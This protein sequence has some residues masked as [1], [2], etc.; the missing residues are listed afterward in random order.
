M[1]RLHSGSGRFGKK[2]CLHRDRNSR[3]SQCSRTAAS[4]RSP[5]RPVSAAL[6][7]KHR[8]RE[9]W[10]VL[11]RRV[12]WPTHYCNDRINCVTVCVIRMNMSVRGIKCFLIDTSNGR[13]ALLR[14]LYLCIMWVWVDF[15]TK[16]CVLHCIPNFLCEIL[17]FIPSPHTRRTEAIIWC[18]Y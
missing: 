18:Y 17:T 4:C 6:G 2:T 11:W 10:S 9:N 8:W 13:F 16:Q 1:G 5:L 14:M 12:K 3:C 15:S 7:L